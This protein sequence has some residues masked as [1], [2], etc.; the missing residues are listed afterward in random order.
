MKIKD[1]K[2]FIPGVYEKSKNEKNAN[3]I[4]AWFEYLTFGHH[5][6]SVLNLNKENVRN[7]RGTSF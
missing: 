1:A 4:I 6:F 7:M 3:N 5:G 2:N